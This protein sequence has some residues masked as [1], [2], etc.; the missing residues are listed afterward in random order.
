[1]LFLG[2]AAAVLRRSGAVCEGVRAPVRR[3]HGKH[4][5][6]CDRGRAGGVPAVR[7]AAAGAVLKCSR[8]PIFL[9]FS[10]DCC[11]APSRWA[12]TWRGC[13]RASA[14]FSTPCCGRWSACSTGC[15]ASRKRTS[16]TGPAT[17]ARCWRSARPAWR[18][19]YLLQRPRG[20]CRST[21]RASGPVA[22]DLG[23]QHRRQ[24]RHQHQLADLH[25]GDHREL[26]DPDG[27]R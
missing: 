19:V 2:L 10:A 15:A 16:S 13:S 18:C 3:S 11:A 23:V 12:R 4:R 17:P 8:S 1:M 21:R 22:P 20:C 6:S 5:V 27:W 26:P 24:L 25:A 7:A 9:A 14:R